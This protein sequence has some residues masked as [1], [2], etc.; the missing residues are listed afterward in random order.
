LERRSKKKATFDTSILDDEEEDDLGRIAKRRQANQRIADVVEEEDGPDRDRILRKMEMERKKKERRMMGNE[1]LQFC[2]FLEFTRQNF[3]SF[4]S[5]QR[6]TSG[7]KE[8]KICI[9]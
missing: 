2:F 3:F 8:R 6:K 4:C 5:H 9:R 7:E 1:M